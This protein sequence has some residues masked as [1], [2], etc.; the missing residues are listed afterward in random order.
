MGRPLGKIMFVKRRK[1]IMFYGFTIHWLVVPIM[2]VI[3]LITLWA[4]HKIIGKLGLY[5]FNI[6]ALAVCNFLPSFE[7][8]GVTPSIGVAFVLFAYISL[9][10][11][12]KKYGETETTKLLMASLV[13]LVSTFAI[14]FVLAIVM[15]AGGEM[16]L[17]WQ[18]FGGNIASVL[19]FTLATLVGYL[20]VKKNAQINCFKSALMFFTVAVCDALIYTIVSQAFLS[21]P[22]KS[23]LIELAIKCALAL[24]V[25]AFVPM[26]IKLF[27]DKVESEAENTEPAQEEVKEETPP[28]KEQESKEENKEA[29]PAEKPKKTSSKKT[30]EKPATKEPA[31]KKTSPAAKPKTQTSKK[32]ATKTAKTAAKSK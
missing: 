20:F 24:M 26:Y 1:I 12:F 21:V 25:S 16:F 4:C 10:I 28:A 9:L 7:M 8:F 3:S 22:L 15:S 32:P 14:K 31:V 6:L 27:E 11:C 17:N 30:A 18:N 19:A 23:F 5:F 29:A 13:V 2:I